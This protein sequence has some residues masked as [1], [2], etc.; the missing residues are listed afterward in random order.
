MSST[1]TVV[2][3]RSDKQ[4]TTGRSAIRPQALKRALPQA[5]LY[6]LVVALSIV[7]IMPFL[8]A[9]ST[10]LKS[11]PQVYTIPPEWIPNPIVW[12]NY[13]DALTYVPFP[14]Y[15]LNTLKITLPSMI[16]TIVSCVVVA[17]GFSRWRWRYRE[18][19]FFICIATMMVPYQVTMVPLFVM[20]SSWGWVNTYL[21]LIV[22]HFFG[23]PYHSTGPIRCRT[24]R[25]LH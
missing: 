21:P 1:T 25:R 15:I 5:L 6:L 16:G 18:T 22:P 11:V 7:F 23:N 12:Q 13:P 10:S 8:W 9:V 2:E 24:G 14:L 17:Y 20:F 3:R 4:E 19:F